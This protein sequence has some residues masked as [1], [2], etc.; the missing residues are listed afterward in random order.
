[1]G[2]EEE[3]E[4][5]DSGNPKKKK[6]ME[7]KLAGDGQE[8]RKKPGVIYLSSVPEGMNVTQ[9]TAFF[10][11]FGRVGRVFLQLYKTDKA[12]GKYNRVFS[13]GWVEFMSK[14]VHNDYKLV[15]CRNLLKKNMRLCRIG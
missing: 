13:E 5:M 1:M 12:K 14:K 9:T 4:E 6:M 2:E 7:R 10:S 11:E 15:S 8:R 3:M